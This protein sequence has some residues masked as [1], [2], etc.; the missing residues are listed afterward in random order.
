MDRL[1]ALPKGTRGPHRLAAMEEAGRAWFAAQGER[2]GFAL[3][4]EPQL[5]GYDQRL[6]RREGSPPIRF[7]VLDL[8]GVLEVREPD[9]FLAALCQGF[10]KAKAWGCGLMLIRRA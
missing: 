2:H 1:K 9:R 8:D 5:D 3:L 4:G 7:S 6:L 10:G